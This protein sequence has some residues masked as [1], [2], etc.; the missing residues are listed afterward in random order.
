[1]TLRH[2]VALTHDAKRPANFAGRFYQ[3]KNW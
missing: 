2:K 3:A 1:M